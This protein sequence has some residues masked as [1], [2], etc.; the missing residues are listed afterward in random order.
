MTYELK[1]D[2]KPGYL[3][4]VVT[5]TNSTENVMLYLEELLH[6]CSA[7]GCS[8]V[9]IEE[10]LE[11]PRLGPVEVCQIA[12]EGSLR[13][14]CTSL[15]IAYVDVNARDDMM[16]LAANVAGSRWLQVAVLQTVAGAE[17]WLLSEDRR[18]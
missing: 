15:A 11:G 17:E 3:H 10:R 9:L 16:E 2:Q 12:S 14:G 18:K 13:C 6:H 1:I 4:A 8:R 7:R 5:G